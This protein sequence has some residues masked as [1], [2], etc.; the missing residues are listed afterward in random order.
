MSRNGLAS[1]APFRMIRIR[2]ARST[3]NSRPVPSPAWVRWTGSVSP[4]TT[5]TRTGRG[6]S[7]AAPAGSATIRA[8]TNS[9]SDRRGRNGQELSRP[10]A[11]RLG[12]RLRRRVLPERAA[13]QDPGV[14]LAERRVR[15]AVVRQDPQLQPLRLASGVEDEA[16]HVGGLRE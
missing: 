2:P 3:T 1:R 13:R 9:G 4:E 11:K 10:R 8:A 15:A 12:R 7:T 6:Q 14:E 5:G 16:L